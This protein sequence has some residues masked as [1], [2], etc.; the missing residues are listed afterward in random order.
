MARRAP[1][2]CRAPAAGITGDMRAH[3]DCTQFLDEV[4]G[5]VAL[6]G[7]DRD[8]A[9]AVGEALDHV[10]RRQPFGMT[11]DA[12]EPGID[13][14]AGAV[15]H[16]PM[17]DEAKLGLHPW[18][19]AVQ[20]GVRVGC[21]AMCPVGA[22][23]A[24]EIGRR[25]TPAAPRATC[26]RRLIGLE[27]LHRCPRLDQ[28]AIHREVIARQQPFDPGLSQHRAEKLGCD[29]AV[30]QPVAVLRKGRVIP[31]RI[32]H[33][34]PD[35]PAE[36]QIELQP[37]HQLTLRANR[38]ERLQQHR[39]QQHLGRDRR[40]TQ[41]GIK[42]RKIA[43]QRLQSRIRQHPYGAQRMIQSYPLLKIDIGEQLPRPLVRSP[44]RSPR[45]MPSSRESCPRPKHHR[46]LQQPA[47][48]GRFRG[49]HS[50]VSV[51]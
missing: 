51:A 21:A 49:E 38:V 4:G 23:L 35:E 15:L 5:I 47:S 11:R 43:R 31:H 45:R 37:L 50:P 20:P 24:P 1:V 33:T 41:P 9:R 25:V 10:E 39:P 6:V 13:D 42:R 44:H 17:A 27:A 3:V 40:P 29:L 2:D 30:Q 14:Q 46:L 18:P 8:G 28:R 26:I 32:V 16:Q 22:L 34:E 19:L 12:G 7:A 36:Q 48:R